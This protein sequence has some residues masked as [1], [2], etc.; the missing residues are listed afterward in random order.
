MELK[1]VVAL[2]LLATVS[3]S[4]FL[5][6]LQFALPTVI[7][8]MVILLSLVFMLSRTLSMP[9]LQAW[10]KTEIRELIIAAILFIAIYGLFSGINPLVYTLTGEEDYYQAAKSVSQDMLF[11]GTEAYKDVMEANH[12]LGIISGFY[13]TTS[14]SLWY[15]GVTSSGSPY[16]GFSIF[17]TPLSMAAQG[18]TNVV[19]IYSAISLFLDFFLDVG[20]KLL[21]LAF[22]FRFI[23]FTRKAGTTLIAL[24][25]GASILFPASVVFVGMFHDTI[26]I[27]TP[28]LSKKALSDFKGDLPTLDTL[29]KEPILRILF[30]LLGELVMTLVICLPLAAFGLYEPCEKWMTLLV[31]P[32]LVFIYQLCYSL[33]IGG[34]IWGLWPE[35]S[36]SAIHNSLIDFMVQVN[37]L[38]VVTY[39]DVILIGIITY[40]GTKSISSALGGEY[41]LPAVQKLI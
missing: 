12:Y 31:Y 9:Q 30:V 25:I 32:L 34:F 11:R 7:L 2:L 19:Y 20:I 29:C 26:E 24:V 38:V 35:S 5:D 10:V 28:H 40:I 4:T 23:P 41:L 21:P 6:D 22:I 3:F 17:M 1:V 14:L 18:L 13:A 8:I 15:A 27:E 16:A 39:I 33:A 37:N 36:V